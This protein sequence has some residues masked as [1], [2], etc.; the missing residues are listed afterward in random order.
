MACTTNNYFRVGLG[1]SPFV[2]PLLTKDVTSE[3]YEME[4][5]FDAVVL[6][7]M[8]LLDGNIVD[9]TN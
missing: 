7:K 1:F 4:V 6:C 3:A 9:F 8:T 5:T 2:S